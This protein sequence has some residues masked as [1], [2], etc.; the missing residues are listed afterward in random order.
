MAC[1]PLQ[2]AGFEIFNYNIY[3]VCGDGCLMEGIASEAASLAGTLV[4]TTCA[5]SSTTT[6]SPSRATPASRSPKMSQRGSWH[7]DGMSCALATQRH[8]SDRARSPSLSGD[9]GPPDFIVLDSHIGYGSP[10]KQDTAA[11]HG[12][13][14]GEEEVRLTKRYYGWPEDASF[15][16]PEVVHEHFADGMG[17][18]GAATRREWMELFDAYRAEYPELAAE[19]D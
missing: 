7:T 8:R 16:V 12:E 17:A 11:A 4:S 3:A 14:L 5:G 1:Q 15:L 2:P 10:N 18:R 6:T 9:E 13:P 19:I